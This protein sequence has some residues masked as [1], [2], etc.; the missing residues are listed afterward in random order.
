MSKNTNEMSIVDFDR[1][2]EERGLLRNGS[3]SGLS[4]KLT[5]TIA[6]ATLDFIV[7]PERVK[8]VRW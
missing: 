6:E 8:H 4:L 7:L 1:G 3:G 5:E 2:E